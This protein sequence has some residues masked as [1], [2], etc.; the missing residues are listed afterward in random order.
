VVTAIRT[1]VRSYDP[2]VRFGG[3]EFVCGLSDTDLDE[4]SRRFEEIREALRDADA[5]ASVS[6]GLAAL[7]P[8]DSLRD[9]TARGDAALYRAKQ[10][11]SAAV[12]T[13]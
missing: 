6:V 13:A 9:L 1:K 5:G 11:K 8:T 10:E 12:A 7:R 2:I 3:D 4:A